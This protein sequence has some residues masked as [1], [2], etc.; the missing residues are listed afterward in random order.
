MLGY[1][2][3]ELLTLSV[4]DTNPDFSKADWETHWHYLSEMKNVRIESRHLTKDR[5]IYP[6]EIS[7]N[8]F[9]YGDWEFNSAFVRDITARK[10]AEEELQKSKE[11]L[12]LKLDSILSPDYPVE[13][14]EFRNI[15]DSDAIQSLMDD[16]YTLTG[17]GIAIL[18]LNGN[19]LISTGWQDICTKFHRVNPET[20]KNCFESDVALTTGATPG[21]IRYYK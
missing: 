4:F 11:K 8:Y 17:I 18:D 2:R 6:V 12:R 13:E 7:A 9:R 15:I 20:Q 3:E 14:A 5:R 19:I 1:S 10:Q 16:F 21:E